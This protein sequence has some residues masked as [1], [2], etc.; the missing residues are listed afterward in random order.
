MSRRRV[1]NQISF[2][3]ACRRLRAEECRASLLRLAYGRPPT[4]RAAQF[5]RHFPLCPKP[6]K[7]ARLRLE[8]PLRRARDTLPARICPPFYLCTFLGGQ[9]RNRPLL[10]DA[11][12]RSLSILCALNVS[13]IFPRQRTAWLPRRRN[14][15]RIGCGS[16]GPLSSRAAFPENSRLLFRALNLSSMGRISRVQSASRIGGLS[17][18]RGSLHARTLRGESAP[19]ASWS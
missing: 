19:P 7:S 10:Y 6:Q 13:Q 9:Y 2:L 16:A 12:R 3:R 5:S 15:V 8:P 17:L 1:Y 4:R 11:R 18:A 14:S